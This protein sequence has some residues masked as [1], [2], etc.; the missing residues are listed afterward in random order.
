[1]VQAVTPFRKSGS[2]Q[3][4]GRSL[5]SDPANLV[6]HAPDGVIRMFFPWSLFFNPSY[7]APAKSQPAAPNG[8]SFFP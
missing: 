4:R 8:I 5:P 7:L 6:A 1:M 2:T 3:W